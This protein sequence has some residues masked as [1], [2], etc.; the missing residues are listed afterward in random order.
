MFEV[1]VGEVGKVCG[2]GCPGLSVCLCLPDVE[3]RRTPAGKKIGVGRSHSP[4]TTTLN[5]DLPNILTC[6]LYTV[7][8][9]TERPR[10]PCYATP[11]SVW[12]TTNV[13]IVLI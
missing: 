11:G 1:E 2:V 12:M 13:S 6:I 9:Y 4:V 7:L 5:T 10:I 3:S 8:Y